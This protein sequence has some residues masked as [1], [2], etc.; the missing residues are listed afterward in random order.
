MDSS[1]TLISLV[2]S[3]SLL[4]NIFTSWG[5]KSPPSLN[6]LQEKTTHL[7]SLWNMEQVTVPGVANVT[8]RSWGVVLMC[9]WRP[10]VC[11]AVSVWRWSDSTGCLWCVDPDSPA[12][13]SSP[14]P[15]CRQIQTLVINVSSVSQLRTGQFLPLTAFGR[16]D[17]ILHVRQ[18]VSEFLVLPPDGGLEL[19]QLRPAGGQ[20]VQHLLTVNIHTLPVELQLSWN[21]HTHTEVAQSHNGSAQKTGVSGCQEW[22]GITMLSPLATCLKCI[23]LK[24]KLQDGY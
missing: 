1:V 3:F 12:G 4:W 19:L 15:D 17:V 16:H 9:F 7:S 13:W 23:L 2:L 5:A 24:T 11:S 14:S 18:C 10:P 6:N 8:W 20:H 21:T 22:T